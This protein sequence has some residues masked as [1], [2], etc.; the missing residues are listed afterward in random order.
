MHRSLFVRALRVCAILLSFTFVMPTVETADAKT[1]RAKSSSK[2]T[3]SKI[4]SATKRTNRTGI[5][6][7][8]RSSRRS[9]V[10]RTKR[11]SAA[12]SRARRARLAR[13]RAAAYARELRA[14][15]T[16]QFRTDANGER[17]PDVRAEAAIIYN[18]MTQEVLWEE[19]AQNP[20]SIASITKVMTAVVFLER[21][22]DLASTVV[23]EPADVRAASTTYLR[24][25]EEV[26]VGDL[27]H[28]LLLG[29][30]NAAARALA[31]TS[32]HG[33]DGFIDRMNAKA[34][35][36]GL[37]NTHYLDPSGLNAGNVSSAFD[38]ARL[39]SLAASDERIGSIMAKSQATISTS[40]RDVTVRNTNKLI[41]GD[42]MV[43]GGKTGFIRKAGYCLATLLQLPQGDSVAVVVLGARSST[44]RFMETRH[45][46]NWLAE[47]TKGLLDARS[48]KTQDQMPE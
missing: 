35:E 27:L 22:V 9:T 10:K 16:P 28:L 41:G 7:T 20:R 30:D 42:F 5:R 11:Y 37:E 46:F 3:A 44:G 33:S 4:R 21:P 14:L 29:S 2:R 48:A 26:A 40:R 8:R 24:A 31:R 34:A 47:R 32:P 19:N 17:I 36:L 43:R 25:Y 6:S 18:P 38:M 39:I 13:A 1:T 45:L 23:I 12:R 15:Q